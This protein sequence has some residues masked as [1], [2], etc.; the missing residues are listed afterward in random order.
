MY[1]RR[2]TVTIE[3]LMVLEESGI[4]FTKMKPAYLKD[5][6]KQTV[7]GYELLIPAHFYYKSLKILASF[8]GSEKN[9]LQP[10]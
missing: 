6:K 1:T 2:M 10:S 3:E 5:K 9:V 4:R 7:R 8:H